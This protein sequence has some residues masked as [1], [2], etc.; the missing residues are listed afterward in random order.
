MKPKKPKNGVK[1]LKNN[2][3]SRDY[4]LPVHEPRSVQYSRKATVCERC[5]EEDINMASCRQCQ[6]V[7]Y[8]SNGCKRADVKDHASVCRA[9]ITVRRYKEERE[10]FSAAIFEPEDG[11][12]TCGFYRD[13]LKPC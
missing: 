7:Y 10:K 1:S 2:S 12:G 5:G 6:K 4:I 9:H 13:S 8:C 3:G 11:C